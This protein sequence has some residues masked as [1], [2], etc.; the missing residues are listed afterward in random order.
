[1]TT[2]AQATRLIPAIRAVGID[3]EQALEKGE[4]DAT[5]YLLDQAGASFGY[6]YEWE[7]YGP[8]S[9]AL[10]A[11]LAALT[12]QDLAVREGLGPELKT[13]VDRVRPL[14]EPRPAGVGEYTWIRL[15]A[16]LDFLQRKAGIQIRGGELPG[17]M[18]TFEQP[19]LEAAIDRL[20][21]FTP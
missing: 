17:Y 15:L 10:A 7:R 20:Q 2:L 1:V 18:D 9:E 16:S 6:S 11:D 8:F 4:L 21:M 12:D 19:I 3:P 5:V 13:A 14:I